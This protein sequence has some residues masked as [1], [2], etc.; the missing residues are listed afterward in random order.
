VPVV[1]ANFEH[2]VETTRRNL[3]Y[4]FT[5]KHHGGSA[6]ASC[7]DLAMSFDDEFE[8]FDRAD[9]IIAPPAGNVYGY[10]VLA[11]GSLAELGTWY[12]QLAEFPAQASG[13]VWH[14]YPIWPIG[15]MAPQNLQGHRCRPDSSVFDR[16]RDLGHIN[17]AQ[18][19]MLKKG[20]N[21]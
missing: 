14:G 21:V 9:G 7:W 6:T 19:K 5:P 20:E 1:Q 2:D 4:V 15:P 11:D 12:Q 8:I 17:D 3:T 13:A 10:T 16:M 18:R